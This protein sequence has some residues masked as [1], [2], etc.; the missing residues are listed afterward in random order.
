MPHDRELV[1]DSGDDIDWIAREEEIE[2]EQLREFFVVITPELEE[3]W[4]I[5]EQELEQQRREEEQQRR[6]EEREQQRREEEQQ[7][8]EADLEQ[9][10][11]EEE[12]PVYV[13]PP[14]CDISVC[15]SYDLEVCAR[16]GYIPTEPEYEFSSDSEE[17]EDRKPP[18][19]IK[20]SEDN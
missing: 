12:Q 7:R 1:Y 4:R 11:Q 9:Q 10:R 8:R 5:L 20:L 6:E 13:Q 2:E 17:E 14:R 16:E 18:K 15:D 19:R 3:R